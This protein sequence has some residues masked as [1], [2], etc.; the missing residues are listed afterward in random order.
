MRETPLGQLRR[1]LR[2]VAILS[3]AHRAGLTPLPARQL[4]TIAYFADALAPVWDLRI[5]DAQLLK[6]RE[7]PMSPELQHDVD[8]LVGM[9]LLVPSA[10]QHRMDQDGL[11]RLDAEYVLNEA[12]SD[13]VLDVASTLPALM[14]QIEFVREVVYA[15]SGLGDTGIPAATSKDASYGDELVDFGDVVDIATVG[16]SENATAQV[17]RRFGVLMREEG[18]SSAEMIHFYVRELYKRVANAA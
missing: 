10:V 2:V 15:V 5:L 16:A 9:G 13:R 18:F 1:Q 17:A 11:W 3:A 14:E 6:R 12:F 7:G 8:R 4:H